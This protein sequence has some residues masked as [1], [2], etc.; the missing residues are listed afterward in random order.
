[1]NL[2]KNIVREIVEQLK[3]ELIP[4]GS[5]LIYSSEKVPH[6]YLPCDGS[7]L[8]KKAYPELYALIGGT[9]GE[10]KDSFFLPDLQGQFI[11]GWDKDGDED[12]E[13]TF[14]SFQ[15]DAFQG[16]GHETEHIK[17]STS[18]SGNHTHTVY[19]EEHGGGMGTIFYSLNHEENCVS[20]SCKRGT[21]N[22]QSS[23]YHSHSFEFD[24]KVSSPSN[25]TYGPVRCATENRPKNVALMFCIKVK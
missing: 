14:G 9:W 10:T 16:H 12:P 5:I 21:A 24:I 23:G 1:M 19:R 6:G 4:I 8:S 22:I 13:R 18:Y 25:S 15:K 3:N 20:D 11:R 17:G 7:E 2:D